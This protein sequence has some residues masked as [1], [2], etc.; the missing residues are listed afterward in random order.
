MT[1]DRTRK[2][3][4]AR[5]ARFV[6]AALTA[7]LGGV[8]CDREKEAIAPDP[9]KTDHDAGALT[10]VDAI[11]ETTGD[12]PQRPDAVPIP[13]LAP[14]PPRDAGLPPPGAGPKPLPCLKVAMPKGE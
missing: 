6:A 1:D 12:A 14:P 3:I 11:A 9:A 5:R 7:T 4:L 10:T 13:C 8:A 2:A